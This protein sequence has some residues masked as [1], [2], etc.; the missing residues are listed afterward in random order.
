MWQEKAEVNKAKVRNMPKKTI[1][2]ETNRLNFDYR[3]PVLTCV[4]PHGV[5]GS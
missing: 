5:G 2:N 1:L 4:A 3:I